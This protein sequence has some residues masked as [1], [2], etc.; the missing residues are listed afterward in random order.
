MAQCLEPAPCIGRVNSAHGWVR[1]ETHLSQVPKHRWQINIHFATRVRVIQIC[2]T[3][4]H[5]YHQLMFPHG[6]QFARRAVQMLSSTT[7]FTPWIFGLTTGGFFLQAVGSQKLR[8][9]SGG[10]F[11]VRSR[12]QQPSVASALRICPG[13]IPR[14][15]G[16]SKP[17][18][19]L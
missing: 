11:L 8:L 7:S 10:I 4:L 6:A 18:A 16:R 5:Y 9:S 17:G 2:C 13:L 3:C 12:I 14:T 15:F 1:L 19:G